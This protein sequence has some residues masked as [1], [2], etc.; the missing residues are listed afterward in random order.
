[1]LQWERNFIITFW[2][3]Q[4]LQWPIYIWSKISKHTMSQYGV[5]FQLI[6]LHIAYISQHVEPIKYHNGVLGFLRAFETNDPKMTINLDDFS[7]IFKSMMQ[8][9]PIQ[10]LQPNCV[11]I[12]MILLLLYVNRHFEIQFKLQLNSIISLF[13]TSCNT[14]ITQKTTF[15]IMFNMY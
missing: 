5:N 8:Q 3:V 7:L 2:I 11:C 9:L 15:K 6:L 13:N 12:R 1:V 10:F 14:N 4:H